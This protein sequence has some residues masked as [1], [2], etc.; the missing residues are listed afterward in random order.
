[1]VPNRLTMKIS[2]PAFAALLLTISSFALAA[3]IYQ[4]RDA[5][6]NP[7]FTDAA[8]EDAPAVE[9][10]APQTYSAKRYTEDYKKFTPAK[11]N[12]DAPP[13][14][15][16][17]IM[18]ITSPEADESVRDNAGNVSVQYALEPAVKTNQRVDLLMDGKVIGEAGSGATVSLSNVDRGTHNLQLR[19]IDLTTGQVV[20]ESAVSSF[21][22]HRHSVLQPKPKHHMN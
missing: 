3:E 4:T 14:P 6:G 21:T 12:G 17:R 20:Q 16:Y 10:Q 1:M 22:L 9:V 18:K 7:V 5:N 19:A 8:P 15:P 11:V 13:G 2:L